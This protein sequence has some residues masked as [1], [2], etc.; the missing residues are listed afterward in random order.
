MMIAG[1]ILILS[2]FGNICAK[3]IGIAFQ[4]IFGIRGEGA[5]VFALGCVCGYPVGGKTALTLYGDGKLTLSECELLCALS[6]NAGPGFVI[7]GIGAV[8]WKD[9]GFGVI[10]YLTELISAVIAAVLLRPLFIKS[11]FSPRNENTSSSD[12]EKSRSFS[13]I[14]SLSAASGV[15]SI[16]K[17]C[18]F[19][20]L[21]E[22]LLTGVF[23]MI[24]EIPG[25]PL[26]ICIISA[27]AE[28]TSG[29]VSA[30]AFSLLG[31]DTALIFGRVMTFALVSW[32][33][34]S[35]HM[36]LNAFAAEKGVV[37]KKYYIVKICAALISALLGFILTLI[38]Y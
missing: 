35:A 23:S 7:A 16:L 14:F 33:G 36:Q 27:A 17:V 29:A 20:V 32:G 4:R 19:V 28:I 30:N 18:G 1:E 3:S 21:F 11:S 24:P 9:A 37:L 13:E 26:L 34:L 6:N 25:K 22:I 12:K 10:L 38:L 2:G 15:S 8:M 5:A 31:S